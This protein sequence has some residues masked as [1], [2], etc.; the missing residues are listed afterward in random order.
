MHAEAFERSNLSDITV[1]E[2]EKE[3]ERKRERKWR[4]G[5]R[6]RERERRGYKPW[7][8]TGTFLRTVLIAARG[9]GYLMLTAHSCLFTGTVS[10]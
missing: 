2:K 8:R 6:E 9:I 5:K 10:V 7:D 4:G 3:R 1:E